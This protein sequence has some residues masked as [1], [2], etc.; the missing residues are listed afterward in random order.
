MLLL[1]LQ[2]MKNHMQ[3]GSYQTESNCLYFA[4]SFLTVTLS[5]RESEW[6]S[7]SSNDSKDAAVF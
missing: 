4:G 1:L 3:C 2:E 5:H 6:P 7:T